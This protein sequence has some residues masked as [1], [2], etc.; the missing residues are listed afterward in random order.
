MNKPVYSS[1]INEDNEAEQFLAVQ[2]AHVSVMFCPRRME[3]WAREV[4]TK[5]DMRPRVAFYFLHFKKLSLSAK[6]FRGKKKK[7]RIIQFELHTP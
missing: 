5:G 6:V 1:C 4:K 3:T 2:L 7:G